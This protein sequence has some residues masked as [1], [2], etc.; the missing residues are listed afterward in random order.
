MSESSVATADHD[1]HATHEHPHPGEKQ[2]FVVALVLAVLTAIE[3]ALYYVEGLNDD[4]LIV[5]LGVLAILK[6][7]GVVLY[8]MHL[9]FDSPIFSRLFV[10]GLVL[11][12]AVY[13]ATLAAMHFFTGNTT[14]V[15]VS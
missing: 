11:A 13:V 8:F 1:V 10:A 9:K 14:F 2:Y 3:V 4:V 15:T 7:V 6:F 12:G 5:T